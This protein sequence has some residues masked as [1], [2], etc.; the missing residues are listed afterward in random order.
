[1]PTL[2]MDIGGMDRLVT[3]QAPTKTYDSEGSLSMAWSTGYQVWAQVI[4]KSGLE[5]FL[6]DQVNAQVDTIFRIYFNAT[7]VPDRTQ[8]IV[9]NSTNYNI[10]DI[11]ELGYQE[12]YEITAKVVPAT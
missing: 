6:H 4:Q 7:V 1:M 8:R 3:I 10:I 2:G 11:M 9:Y 12:R 5:K